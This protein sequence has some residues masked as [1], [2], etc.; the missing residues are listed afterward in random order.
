M[1]D[2]LASWKLVAYISI[3]TGELLRLTKAHIGTKSGINISLSSYDRIAFRGIVLPKEKNSN[4]I[5]HTDAK[6]YSKSR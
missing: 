4:V 1:I 5:R 2:F 3:L 6:L